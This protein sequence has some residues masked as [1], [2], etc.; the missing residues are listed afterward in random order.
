[1]MDESGLRH[2]IGKGRL[3]LMAIMVIPLLVILKGGAGIRNDLQA[4][5]NGT[6][7]KLKVRWWMERLNNEFIRQGQRNGAAFCDEEGNLNQA[8][9]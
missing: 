8:L 6:A 3:G 2:H 4:I 1:M 9:Q 7:S 5:S